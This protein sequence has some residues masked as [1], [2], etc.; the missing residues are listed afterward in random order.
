[1]IFFLSE[2]VKIGPAP[3]HCA[4]PTAN[5]PYSTPYG[6]QPTANNPYSTPCA[7]LDV[8]LLR[9]ILLQLVQLLLNLLHLFLKRLLQ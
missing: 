8:C 6:A 4:Q 7:Y 3:Q 9:S 5:N 2:P 1:M